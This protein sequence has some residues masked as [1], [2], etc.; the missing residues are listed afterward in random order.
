MSVP[1]GPT[2]KR[3]NAVGA[4]TVFTIPF[5]VI[6][7]NDLLITLN[8]VTVTTGFTLTGLGNPSSTCTFTAAPTGDL[9]F[10]QNMIFERLDDYQLNGDFLSDTVNTDFDRTWL[11]LK[12]LAR[13]ITQSLIAPEPEG[14]PALPVV[15]SRANKMLAFDAAGAPVPSNLTLAQLEQQPALALDSAALAAASALAAANS[16]TS[17]GGYSAAAQAWANTPVDVV[18]SGGLYSS[19]HWATK[20]AASATAAAN[21][22]SNAATTLANAVQKTG[23]QTMAGPLAVTGGISSIP[24]N[25]EYVSTQQTIAVA[26]LLSLTHG[27]GSIPKHVQ[28]DA[29]CITADAG[30]SVGD[31][32]ALGP[33]TDNV[34]TVSGVGLSIVK[35]ATTLSIRIGNAQ[36][37][38]CLNK[39]TGAA[40]FYANSSWQLI[41]RAWA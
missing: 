3:Y 13:G 5:L 26:A 16:S 10:Q 31:I 15:A 30:Y 39:T 32:V 37:A 17:A 20:S 11:A 33:G 23:S 36:F 40:T 2:F 6:D 14:I 38:A 35:N 18:V 25:K 1:A 27:L 19:L 21:S 29:I 4:A 8:G 34:S 7:A 41:V 28:V 12:Q 24:F 22:A 9:L